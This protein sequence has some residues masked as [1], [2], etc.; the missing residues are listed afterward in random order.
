M[1]QWTGIMSFM[2]VRL[3]IGE[4]TAYGLVGED[5]HSKLGRKA[6]TGNCNSNN[7]EIILH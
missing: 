1:D 5:F 2:A 6:V 4:I 7:F 3:W